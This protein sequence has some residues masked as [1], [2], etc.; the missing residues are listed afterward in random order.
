M[1]FRFEARHVDSVAVE[2]PSNMMRHVDSVAVV[3][4]SILYEA[5]A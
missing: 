1:L 4:P 3:V 5:R 2:V